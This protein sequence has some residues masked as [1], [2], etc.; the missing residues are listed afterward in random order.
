MTAQDTESAAMRRAIEAIERL[1]ARVKTLEGQ[2]NQPIAVVGMGCRLPGGVDGPEDLWRILVESTDAVAEI[3]TSR[4][5]PNKT[6]SSQFD[7]S[8]IRRGG[9][10][11][12]VDTFDASFFRVSPREAVVLDPQQ[13]LFLEVSWKAVEDAGIDPWSLKGTAT[14]VFAG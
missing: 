6:A 13:R 8:P 12:N 4:W 7:V 14:G 5:D 11:E 2:G 9:F 10:I 3:P 1:R